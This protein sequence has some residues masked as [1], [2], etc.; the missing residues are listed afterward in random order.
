MDWYAIVKF[1]HIVAAMAWLGGSLAML[2]ASTLA[3]TDED[4]GAL[5]QVM[6]MMHG[7]ALPYFIPSSTAVLVTGL[8][9]A[10][11][12]L[13]FGDAWLVLALAGVAVSIGIGMSVL[14]PVGERIAARAEPEG[15]SPAVMAD[16]RRIMRFGRFEFA[17]MLAVVALMVFKPGWQ[18]TTIL[19]A[20]GL[21]VACAAAVFLIPRRSR[22]V[23]PA[24]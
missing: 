16:A 12:R 3:A 9:M 13:G 23:L 20:L 18:D 17:V 21:P 14:K 22:A 5:L 15:T 7:L 24:A 2:I 1:V 4:P 8:A 10:W 6:K 11:F 19:L